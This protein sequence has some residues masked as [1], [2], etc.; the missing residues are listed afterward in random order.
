MN[1]SDLSDH[2]EDGLQIIQ[3]YGKEYSNLWKTYGQ[4]VMEPSTINE[5]RLGTVD[6]R[7]MEDG[8]TTLHLDQYP[9]GGGDLLYQRE[10]PPN[11]FFRPSKGKKP[12]TS[13]P[14]PD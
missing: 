10:L 11:T 6:P 7:A 13:W 5:G 3:D 9:L 8:P 1:D 12:V 2:G 4:R 14:Q